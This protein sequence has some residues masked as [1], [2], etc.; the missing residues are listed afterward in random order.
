MKAQLI[1]QW[2]SMHLLKPSL[3]FKILNLKHKDHFH[4][5]FKTKVN[6]KMT[7]KAICRTHKTHIC[8]I[9]VSSTVESKLLLLQK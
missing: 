6:S 4:K 7:Y 1:S 8:Q 9:E 3:H 5:D 2:E